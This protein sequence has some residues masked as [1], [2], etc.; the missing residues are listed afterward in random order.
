[1]I[2]LTLDVGTANGRAVDVERR[3]AAHA[4]T[5]SEEERMKHHVSRWVLLAALVA[6]LA[7]CGQQ[8]TTPPALDDGPVRSAAV[9][10]HVE[11]VFPLEPVPF[12]GPSGMLDE[13]PAGWFVQFAAP[14]RVKGGTAAERAN[15]RALFRSTAHAERIAYEERF[16]FETLYNGLSVTAGPAEIAKLAMLP[17]VVAVFPVARLEIPEVSFGASPELMTALAMTGADIA[18]ND[19]G[20]TGSGVKVAVMDTGIDYWHPDLGGG[21]GNRVTHGWDFVGDA[22]NAGDPNNNVPVPDPDPMDC[23]GHG[24]HV[25]GI[26]GADGG[27]VGVAPGVTFGAYKVFGCV[28]STTADIMLAAMEMAHADGMHV[29]NMSIGAAFQW[30]QYPTA[31]AASNLV[32]AG[33]VVVASIGNSGANGVY[34]AGAPGLG[35]HV[36]GVASFDNSH[37]NALTF[38]VDPSGH[39]VPYLTL[40]TAEDPP[41]SG[42]TPEVVWVGQGCQADPYLDDP[43]GKVALVVRGGCTFDEKYQRAADAGAVG[44]VIHNNVTG[45]FAGGGVTTRGIFGI[46]ISLADGQHVR[47]L[48]DG[49]DTVTFTWTDVRVNAPNP[50]GNLISSFSSYGLA[51]DL[52]LKPDIGAPGGLIRSTYPLALGRYATV[53]GTSMSAPHV[54]GGVALLLEAQPN[55]PAHDVRGILQNAADPKVWSGNP[56]LGFLDNVHRQGAGM[57]DIP[58]AIGAT[59]RVTPAKIAAGESE[60]GPYSTTLWITNDGMSAVTYDAS[61]VNALSTGGSTFSPGFFL[62]NA[63]VSFGASSVTVPAGGS[64]SLHVTISP[65]TAPNLGQYGGYVVL[66]PQGG[67]DV[68]RVPYAG[69]VGDYQSIVTLMP[70]PFGFPWLARVEGDLYVWQPEGATYSMHGDDIPF[71]LVHLDH[72]A[73]YMEMRIL[74]AGNGRP[75]HPNFHTTNVF[76]YLPR[77]STATGFFAFAW[78][79]TRAHSQRT[80]GRGNAGDLFMVVPDGDY[81]IELRVL[82]ALGDRANPAHWEMWTSPVITIDRNVGNTPPRP[83]QPPGRNR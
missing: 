11:Q 5:G 4:V 44:V 7:A 10:S 51:P 37:I 31:V 74:H 62:G 54:A 48:L 68:V 75:V 29:L 83:V 15:E 12:T 34:S 25:A 56:G 41:T 35:E 1:M 38:E 81:V 78:D 42:T 55:V 43:D 20:L 19:L 13:T 47:S 18:Q 32:D 69:F 76:E 45:L 24:T 26:V 59:T 27:V 21:W 22:F 17:G 28:G 46:G 60:A 6:L 70:T 66:T 79:G 57:L 14:P 71:F 61:F 63:S 16:D 82:K 2:A 40:A 72:Q 36:I 8:V 50:T 67:G 23:N 49:S 80:Q 77:N 58:G 52:A 73:Q 33:M 39:Q 53:S 30:P 65:A 3:V 9:P 64:A